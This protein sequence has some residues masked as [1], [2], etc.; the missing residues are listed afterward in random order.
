MTDSSGGQRFGRLN[1]VPATSEFGWK[2]EPGDFTPWLA[3]NLDLLAREIGL[4]LEFRDKE[5]AVGRYSLDLLL[6]DDRSRTVAVENQ[7]GRTD[8]DH[9][10]KLLTYGAGTKADVV[11]WISESFTEEHAAAL[12]WL[13]EN[14]VEGVGFFGIEL[15]LLRIDDSKAAPHFKV[16]VRPN[17]WTKQ[18]RPSPAEPVEWTWDAYAQDMKINSQRIL[19]CRELAD[20]LTAALARRNA[21]LDVKFRKG[22]LGYQRS[23]GYNVF[24]IDLYWSKPPRIAVKLPRSPEELGLTNPFPQLEEVWDPKGREWGWSLASVEDIPDLDEI[25]D[26]ALRFNP[27]ESTRPT[28]G[29]SFP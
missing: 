22:Y 12:D 24:I 26:L 27:V 6:A 21:I 23:G 11:I 20:K 19:V 25:V 2:S 10:G 7:F 13:N 17:E 9:L 1:K 18:M 29:N 8:H 4:P 28:D 14:T 16:I 5:H 15:E 3:D